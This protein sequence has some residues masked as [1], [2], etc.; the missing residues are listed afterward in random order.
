MTIV[1]VQ[2]SDSGVQEGVI[3]NGINGIVPETGGVDPFEV[4]E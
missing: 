2:L 4:L 1:E 3:F